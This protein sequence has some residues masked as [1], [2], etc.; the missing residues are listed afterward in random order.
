MDANDT[1]LMV[2]DVQGKLVTLM[3]EQE[4]LF[5]NIERLIKT[6]HLFNIP[7]IWSEQAPDKIG[8]TVTSIAALLSAHSAP[9]V[10]RTFS[11][12]DCP[13]LRQKLDGLH[14]RHVL[15]AGIETH[16]CVYQTAQ[17]LL[18]H[19][20]EVD[21]IADAVSSRV[22]VNKEVALARLLQ[23]GVGI[24]SLELAV[25]ELLKSADHPTFREVMGN[26]R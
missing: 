17:D 18:R 24:T 26:I 10:K 25:C 21:V 15:I 11:C 7:I 22:L 4:R 12:Y 8:P 3:H 16:V 6:A 1:V 14:R 13:P 20:Y 2:I 5:N 23:Q 19:G 9:I